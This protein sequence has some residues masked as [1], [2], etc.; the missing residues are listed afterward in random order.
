MPGLWWLKGMPVP[1]EWDRLILRTLEEF[2]PAF[3]LE[4]NLTNKQ[5][6]MYYQYAQ[7]QD[8]RK[9]D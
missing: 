4:R 8:N 2:A 9:H 3:D 5:K 1:L 6:Y 7:I